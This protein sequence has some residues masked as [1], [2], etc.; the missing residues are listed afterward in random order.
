MLSYK[1]EALA[2]VCST[3]ILCRE[4]AT[5]STGLLANERVNCALQREF[6]DVFVYDLKDAW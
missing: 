6:L 1:N 2:S 4:I 5:T 3:V